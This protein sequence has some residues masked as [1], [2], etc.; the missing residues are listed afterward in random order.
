ML[1]TAITLQE[2]D[3]SPEAVDYAVVD[4]FLHGTVDSEAAWSAME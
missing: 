3:I 2:G 1:A 4:A